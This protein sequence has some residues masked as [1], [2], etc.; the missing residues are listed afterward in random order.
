M[1]QKSGG[2]L[3]GSIRFEIMGAPVL[4]VVCHCRMCQR[5]SGAAFMG[6]IFFESGAVSLTKGRPNV[7]QGSETLRRHFCSACGSPIYVERTSSNRFGVLVGAMDDP[8]EFRPSMHICTSSAQ[9]W[10]KL[11]D[12]LPNFIE[13]PPGMSATVSY[14]PKSGKVTEPR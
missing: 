12:S 2:C 14:D 3:C 1:A 7:Y 13:K 8:S 10:L 6:L 4:Q 5:A 9:P 11:A